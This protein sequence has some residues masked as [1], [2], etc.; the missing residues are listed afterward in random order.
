MAEL[1]G[2]SGRLSFGATTISDLNHNIHA[3][4]MDLNVDA[5]E[6]TDFS[7][8]GDRAY[9]RGLK[10]WTATCEGYE[11]GT[12]VVAATAVGSSASLILGVSSSHQYT[13]TALLTGI[14]ASAGVDGVV[15]VSYKF[16]G[17]GAIAYTEDT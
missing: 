7:D 1:S 9:I 13:G 12:N 14:G 5:L 11:D 10:G 3:W 17:S 16:Q 15:T 6:V 8:S 2:Y 4:T